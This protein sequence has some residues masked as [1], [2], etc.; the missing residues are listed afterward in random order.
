MRYRIFRIDKDQQLK[1]NTT[2][3]ALGWG[4]REVEYIITSHTMQPGD[5]IYIADLYI[6]VQEGGWKYLRFGDNDVVG[7]AP[8]GEENANRLYSQ[9]VEKEVA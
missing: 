6:L 3:I 9:V 4:P 8:W 5:V 7:G 1:Y 2:G